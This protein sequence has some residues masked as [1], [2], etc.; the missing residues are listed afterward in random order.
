MHKEETL[1]MGDLES[2]M[3]ASFIMNSF[4]K[5]GFKPISVKIIIDKRPNKNQKSCFVTFNNLEEANN[6]LFKLNGKQIPNTSKFFKLNLTKKV[7][8]IKKL[9]L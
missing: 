8:L 9:Y 4:I 1:W 7:Q 2:W 3:N 5:F 6:A